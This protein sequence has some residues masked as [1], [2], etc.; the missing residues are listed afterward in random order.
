MSYNTPYIWPLGKNN[1]L[2]KFDKDGTSLNNYSIPTDTVP[3][4]AISENSIWII[5]QSGYTKIIRFDIASGSYTEI[6]PSPANYLMSIRAVGIDPDG[7]VYVM[8]YYMGTDTNYHRI[9]EKYNSDG[10]YVSYVDIDV[11]DENPYEVDFDSD[12]NLWSVV[13]GSALSCYSVSTGEKLH[14][15]SNLSNYCIAVDKND[16]LWTDGSDGKSINKIDPSDGSTKISITDCGISGYSFGSIKRITVDTDNN[17]IV[18]AVVSNG[19]SEG[20]I[21]KYD[22]DGNSLGNY[23]LS[24]ANI[25]LYGDLGI[26]SDNNIWVANNS[27]G[28]NTYSILT[29]IDGSSLTKIGDYGAL[30]DAY[31]TED[32]T[33]LQWQLHSGGPELSDHGVIGPDNIKYYKCASWAEGDTHGGD[34][35]K[36]SPLASGEIFDDITDQEREQGD[37]DYRKIYIANEALCPWPGTKAWIVQNTPAP[38]DQIYISASGT[39]SDTVAQASGYEFVQPSGPN[40]PNVCDIGEIPAQGYHHLWIKRVVDN[41]AMEGYKNKTFQIKIGKS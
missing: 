27:A 26:D 32:I 18:L 8:E 30:Q 34:I 17:V 37:T 14:S 11:V 16:Y 25:A 1:L 28:N 36:D 6:T 7:F 5:W 40:D 15:Y 29:K 35:D 41:P 4:T 39:N 3:K 13:P 9:I 23:H 10:T 2:Y 12:K 21:F 20:Y 31:Q 38:N 33:G 22:N 19:S 24:S